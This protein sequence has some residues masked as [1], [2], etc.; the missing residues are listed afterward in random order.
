MKLLQRHVIRPGLLRLAL[1]SLCLFGLHMATCK[2]AD[3]S[4]RSGIAPPVEVA[5]VVEIPVLPAVAAFEA[6]FPPG[7]LAYYPFS[8]NAQDVSYHYNNATMAGDI[9]IGDE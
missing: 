6:K 9:H 1:V 8:G 3:N 4:A 5:P 7:L 2:S